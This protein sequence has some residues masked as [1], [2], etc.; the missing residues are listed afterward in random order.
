[1]GA[2]VTPPP[3]TLVVKS[4]PP[5]GNVG[6]LAARDWRLGRAAD[7]EISLIDIAVSRQHALLGVREGR[8]CIRDLG[9]TRGTHLNAERLQTILG[10]TVLASVAI[11]ALL[12]GSLPAAWSYVSFMKVE[13]TASFGIPLNWLFSIHIVFVLAMVVRHAAITWDALRGHLVEDEPADTA[14]AQAT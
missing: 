14:P 13:S 2:E 9:S 4:G 5:R 10:C 6:P 7:N 11:V 1:M 12:L 3:I 8:W